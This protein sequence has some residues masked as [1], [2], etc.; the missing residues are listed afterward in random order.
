MPACGASRPH[1]MACVSS[2][3]VCPNARICVL[4]AVTPRTRVHLDGQRV[5][6]MHAIACSRPALHASACI[7]PATSARNA[8]ICV[9]S[10]MT[11]RTRVHLDGHA[12][13]KCTPLRAVGQHYTH[14]RAFGRPHVPEMHAIACSRPALHASACIW[15]AT[16]ARNARICVQS[17]M[18]PRIRVHLAA[19][20]HPTCTSLRAV[21]SS[22]R[23]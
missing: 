6:E 9:Q 19:R 14:P 1:A 22:Q 2:A 15:P 17:A 20:P 16:S 3:L 7:W 5:P 11:P 4:S 21:G 10:A 8:R 23:L 18:T 12:C 13:P